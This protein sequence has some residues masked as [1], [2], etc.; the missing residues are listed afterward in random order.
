MK[1]KELSRKTGQSERQILRIVEAGFVQKPKERGD[2]DEDSAIAG[3]VAY[4]QAQASRITESRAADAARREKAEANLAE[5]KEAETTRRLM[6]RAYHTHV[7][8][9]LGAQTRVV[10]ENAHYI[11]K[12][13]RIRLLK[14]ISEIRPMPPKSLTD[15]PDFSNGER[16]IARLRNSQN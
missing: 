2:Y 10:I 7:V 5:L 15:R 4:Y 3:V 12:P 8:G 13:A 16:Q 14:S 1:L 9:D 6:P 11:P